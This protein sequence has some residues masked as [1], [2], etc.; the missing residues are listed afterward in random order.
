MNHITEHT[1]RCIYIVEDDPDIAKIIKSVLS[2]FGFM[3]II[4]QNAAE[5]YRR[6]R[7]KTPDLCIVDLGLPDADGM[8]VVKNLQETIQCGVIILTGRGYIGDKIMGLELGAD[9]YIVK[10]FEPRELVARV[11]SILRRKFSTSQDNAQTSEPICFSGWSFYPKTNLLRGENGQE[12]S[13][14]TSEAQLLRVFLHKPNR[15][16]T[17]EQLLGERDISPF[18][19]SIDVRISRLRRKIELDPQNP[20]LIRTVYGAGYLFTVEIGTI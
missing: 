4:C 1:T 8:E 12:W 5:L 3:P 18:D 9:D 15:I 11:R 10:P 16:L 17:R 14:S 19:R 13:L 20:K 2:D 7:N 6:L